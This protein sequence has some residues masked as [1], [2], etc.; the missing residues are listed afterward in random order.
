M[1]S[2][3]PAGPDSLASDPLGADPLAPTPLALALGPESSG[4]GGPL[5]EKC[6]HDLDALRR[7]RI[8]V[9][10]DI[11]DNV[12]LLKAMLAKSGFTNVVT[13]GNGREALECLQS[14]VENGVSTIDAVL[15]DIMMPE[16]DGFQLCRIMRAHDEWA[17]IPV[18]MITANA[19]WQDK[20]A[21]ASYEAGATDIL[22]KPIRRVEL[23]PRVISALALK[24]ERDLRKRRE[25]ELE[26]EL[27]ERRIVEARLQHLVYHDDLT[28]LCNRR[29]LERHLEEAVRRCR[30]QRR[31]GALFYLDLDQFKVINDTEGH[32]TGDRLLVEVA[33]TLRAH[34]GPR[35]ILARVS[36]DEYAVLMEGVSEAQALETAEQLRALMD[37]F[38]FRT[39]DRTYHIGASIGVALLRHDESAEPSEL[40]ARADQAC[41]VAKTHG[42]NIVHL[43]N[44]DDT[45]M[46]TLRRAI[47]WVPLI[48]DALANDRFRLVFQPLMDLRTRRVQ[49]C[50]AL[51]RMVDAEGQLVPP[52]SF[53]PVAEHMGLIHDIDLWV[54]RHAIDVLAALPPELGHVELNVNLSSYA[55]QDTALLPLLRQR[56]QATGVAAHRLTFEITETAAVANFAQTREMILKLRELGCRFA[57]DDFGSGFSTFSYIKELPADFLKID[58]AFVTNLVND[59]VDQALVRS[60]IKIA[61]TLGKRTIAEFVESQEV[62]EL[63]G[64]FGVDYAQGFH[65][66]RPVASLEEALGLGRPAS[67][68]AGSAAG[69]AGGPSPSP[70]GPSA[71]ASPAASA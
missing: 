51:I 39:E 12:D 32:Q 23:L 6:I 42:R 44:D 45:E 59:P 30:E 60:M 3:D 67:S 22:F 4:H 50:E 41:Y 25:Q 31:D 43:Y 28:G 66:G 16:M 54:V 26:T 35:G 33:N 18:T 36:A 5:P 10:D 7:M 1:S 37:A 24:R 11:P 52:A 20:V 61:R 55:F 29:Y 48:R 9:V 14:Y 40:L 70:A 34:I 68:A 27:A 15:L 57:L 65:I 38:T 58:G 8:L 69:S 62:L 64:E 63:L 13:A 21:R 56:L 17:D 47:H 19:S 46:L 2:P 53:I 49:R 71:A